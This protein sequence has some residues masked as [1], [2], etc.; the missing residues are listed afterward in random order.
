MIHALPLLAPWGQTEWAVVAAVAVILGI[1]L[2]AV[3][4]LVIP[5]FGLVGILGVCSTVAG[6]ALAWKHLGPLWGLLAI[7]VSVAAATLLI[8]AFPRTRL[9]KK[10]MLHESDAGYT[11][12]AADLGLLLGR[13]GTAM[14]MLRPSGTAEIDDRRVDVVTD[15]TFLDAGTPVRVVR[16]EG[17]R[18]VVEPV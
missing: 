16:V 8:W 7:G 10:F 4:I 3:E 18:V 9:G 6:G 17:A 5:G 1:V 11:A 15:G 14:T 2:L 12:P 13:R